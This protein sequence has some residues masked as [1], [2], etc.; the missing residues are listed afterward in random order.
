[1]D[2]MI[3]TCCYHA[4]ILW[5]SWLTKELIEQW[6]DENIKKGSFLMEIELLY[7]KSSQRKEFKMCSDSAK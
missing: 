1:M 3:T 7:H 4:L 5:S 6:A 2:Y